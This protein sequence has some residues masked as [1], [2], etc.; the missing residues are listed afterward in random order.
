MPVPT[1]QTQSSPDQSAQTNHSN[2]QPWR[3]G[4]V[5]PLPKVK[6]TQVPVARTPEHAAGHSRTLRL[7]AIVPTSASGP[8]N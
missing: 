8:L 5:L 7:F 6:I 2:S 3:H 4:C 1:P